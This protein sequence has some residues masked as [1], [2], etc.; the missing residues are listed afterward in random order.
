MSDHWIAYRN[1]QTDIIGDLPHSYSSNVNNAIPQFSL[2]KL[3]VEFDQIFLR[4][5]KRILASHK[6]VIDLYNFQIAR[7]EKYFLVERAIFPNA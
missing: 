4:A 1:Y 2:E 5:S 3:Q 7:A 6:Y